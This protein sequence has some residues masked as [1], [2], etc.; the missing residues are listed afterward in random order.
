MSSTNHK[1]RV[2]LCFEDGTQ[3]AISSRL[4]SQNMGIFKRSKAILM[5]G[6]EEEPIVYYKTESGI[7]CMIPERKPVLPEA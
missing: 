1:Y 5:L 3:R 4:K 6:E 7:Q 2:W